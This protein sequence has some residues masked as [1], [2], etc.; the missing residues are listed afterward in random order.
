[1]DLSDWRSRIDALDRQVVDLLNERMRCALEIGQIK[2]VGGQPIR[3][4][5]REKALLEG[6]KEY[7]EGPMSAEAIDDIFNRVMAEARSLEAE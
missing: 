4:P 7:N 6:L 5:A 1:M 2:R 3:V